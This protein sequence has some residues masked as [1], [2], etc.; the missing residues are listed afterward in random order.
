MKKDQ[1]AQSRGLKFDLDWFQVDSGAWNYVLLR[2]PAP[3][4]G[5]TYRAW[6]RGL[7]SEITFTSRKVLIMVGISGLKAVPFLASCV[8]ASVN[9]PLIPKDLT[10]PFQQRLAVYGPSGTNLNFNQP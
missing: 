9:Y 10:T 7:L 4:D 5:T 2:V 1:H 3:K 8:Y 6:Y